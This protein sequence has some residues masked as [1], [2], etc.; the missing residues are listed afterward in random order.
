M[1]PGQASPTP[2]TPRPLAARL[3]ETL[4]VVAL[5]AALFASAGTLRW[6]AGW[7]YLAVVAGGL[8]A[9]RTYVA[10]RN[11]QVLVRR[12]RVG[13]GTRA[14]DVVWLA[15]FWPLMLVAPVV[16]G[17]DT[18]R[19]GHRPL[20]A[21]TVPLGAAVHAAGM[22]LSAQAM[23]ANPFFEGTARIQ[24]GQVVVDTGPYRTVRHPG[25]VGLALWALGSPLLLRSDLAFLPALLTAAWVALRTALEDR[26]L[27]RE[28]A[29][30]EDY[31]RRVRWKLLPGIW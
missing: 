27:R 7:I 2:A 8:L 30:Y 12:D 11:P 6:P 19:L 21:W 20:A 17:V 10:A 31:A 28:L 15:V 16:A 9:H 13:Q 1:E 24:P 14:W 22:A 26:M 18:Q 25:Y 4:L 29:G 3:A 23:A 5:V